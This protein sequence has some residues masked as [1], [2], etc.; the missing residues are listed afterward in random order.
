MNLMTIIASVILGTAAFLTLIR[1]FRAPSILDRAVALDV[2]VTILI[3]GLAVEAAVNRHTHTL[4]V[5]LVL[6]LVSFLGTVT[7]ARFIPR[8]DQEDDRHDV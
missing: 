5:L 8:D 3:A 2:L 6:A 1:V 7:V 4:P